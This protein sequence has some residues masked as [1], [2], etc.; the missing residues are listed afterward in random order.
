MTYMPRRVNPRTVS[1][2]ISP[3]SR[4]ADS[5]P[6]PDVG[7]R[8]ALHAF[9]HF[10]RQLLAHVWACYS[11]GVDREMVDAEVQATRN[12]LRAMI[13]FHA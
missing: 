12:A 6:A 13:E 1:S 8:A 10:R 5:G 9:D 4:A 11:H 3:L 7:E 2:H